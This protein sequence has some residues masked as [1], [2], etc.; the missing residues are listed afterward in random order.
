[1]TA[2]T[3]CASDAAI[4]DS[5]DTASHTALEL[6]QAS[7]IL[8]AVKKQG[9]P[10]YLY[11]DHT[12]T[13]AHNGNKTRNNDNN[14]SFLQFQT[15]TLLHSDAPPQDKPSVV[16]AP[17]DAPAIVANRLDRLTSLKHQTAA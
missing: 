12:D 17:G 7:T 6:L 11:V 13:I 9:R 15:Y 2:D 8:K 1:M 3:C 16:A 5:T 14:N 10:I 4:T